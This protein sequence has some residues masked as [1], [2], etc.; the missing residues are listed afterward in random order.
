MY[1]KFNFLKHSLISDNT[2]HNF[3]YNIQITNSNGGQQF[4]ANKKNC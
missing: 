3:F 1:I 4:R 2:K